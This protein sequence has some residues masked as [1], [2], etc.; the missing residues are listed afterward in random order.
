MNTCALLRQIC[1]AFCL[2][3][4]IT[5]WEQITT[6]QINTTY[7]V[8]CRQEMQAYL[9]QKINPHVFPNAA[10]VM[11]NIELVTAHIRH[12]S[13]AEDTGQNHLRFFHTRDG[14]S[15]L[16][17]GQDCWRVCNYIP[18][19][20]AF[21]RTDSPA[22]LRSAGEAFGR[23]AAQCTDLD[24]TKLTETIPHFHDTPFRL[25][26]LM[27][28]AAEDRCGR[29][30]AAK[31]EMKIIA[32]TQAFAGSLKAKQD[33]GALPLRVTHNDTKLSNVLFDRET[34]RP[35]TVIDLDTVMPGL[36]AYDFGDA[37]RSAANNAAGEERDFEHPKLD[38]ALFRAFAE[39]YLRETI[40]FLTHEERNTLAEGV[41]TATLE[42]AIRYLDDF[43]TGDHYFRVKNPDQNLR[44]ARRQLALFQDMRN[45]Y[46]DMNRILCEIAEQ[47]ENR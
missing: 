28:H 24:S 7:R 43:I 6:G 17:L 8:I 38:L 25:A 11:Q 14:G 2:S 19:S 29:C 33:R 4:E 1:R 27:R 20:I 26:Q 16:R 44:K 15:C 9:V 47:T 18:H 41:L 3:G 36:I 23:F 5:A 32:Q 12:K 31:N 22:I 30:A 40:G 10:Q 13:G 42:L 35:L 45:K 21:S 34:L 46:D 37:I 39:G